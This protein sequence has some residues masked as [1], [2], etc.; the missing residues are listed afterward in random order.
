MYFAVSTE[1]HSMRLLFITQKIHANDDDLA[2][3]IL[4]VKEFITQ[5]IEVEVICLEKGA[6]DGS[7]P[8]HSLGKEEGAGKFTRLLRFLK[9]ITTLKYD[10]VFVH[11]NPQYFTYGGWWWFL[12]GIPTY[13]WYTHYTMTPHLF[14]A[15]LFAKRLFAATAQSL[16]QYESNPK[17]VVLGHGIDTE[18]WG[19]LSDRGRDPYQLLSVHRLSRSKRFEIVIETLALLGAKYTVTVY[20]RPIDPAYFEELKDLVHTRALEGRVHFKG[21]VPMHELPAIYSRYRLMINMASETIDKTMLEALFLGVY[22]VTTPR[23]AHAIGLTTYP[24][25]ESP[26]TL[27]QFIESKQWDTMSPSEGR[28]LVANKHSLTHLVQEMIKHMTL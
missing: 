21:P 24:A 6:F 8:V 7:F 1:K 20:G 5:G 26:K 10:T 2:F 18:F 16:P 15:G 12:R 19:V 3:T 11:M 17:K 22:P 13:L 9:L 25:D 14:L 23:N 28:S 4:W 27:A